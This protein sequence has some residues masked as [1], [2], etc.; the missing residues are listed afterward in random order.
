MPAL[1]AWSPPPEAAFPADNAIF[2][3][4]KTIFQ[5]A[6]A[7]SPSRNVA[8]SSDKTILSS[9]KV[10]S[11]SR[12][13]TLSS[14]KTVLSSD[15][16]AM[17]S[18]RTTLSSRKTASG[19]GKIAKNTG[20]DCFQGGRCAKSD[21]SGRSRPAHRRRL[22]FVNEKAW[23]GSR[24]LRILVE[25]QTDQIGDVS[26]LDEPAGWWRRWSKGSNNHS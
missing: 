17:S 15:K 10:I 8:L 23:R 3:S 4:R 26:T 7:A 6:E 1:R 9:C 5:E 18:C 2:P 11:S 21:G 12:I 13:A 19:R 20:F 16:M 25:N 14:R 24:S 22:S